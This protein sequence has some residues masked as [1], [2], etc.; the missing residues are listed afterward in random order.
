MNDMKRGSGGFFTRKKAMSDWNL[1][2][3]MK[4][5]THGGYE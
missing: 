1:V 2:E 3:F 5:G 4:V